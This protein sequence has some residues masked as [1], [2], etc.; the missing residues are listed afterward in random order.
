MVRLCEIFVLRMG[1]PIAPPK[2]FQIVASNLK[3]S[4]PTK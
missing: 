1:F 4:M 2:A 3:I